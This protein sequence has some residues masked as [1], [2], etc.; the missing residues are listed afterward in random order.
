M[1]HMSLIK[2]A[3]VYAPECLG[4]KDVLL[5]G[6]KICKIGENLTVPASWD[7]EVIDGSG[8]L[9]LP[10]FIDS[11]VHVLGG[12]GEG[13]FASRTPADKP[14]QRPE[15]RKGAPVF[16][17]WRDALRAAA[18]RDIIGSNHHQGGEAP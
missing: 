8:M 13:G 7:A 14:F 2:K 12:G 17:V 10:G 15:R 1:K 9:L 6:G 4:Q 16:F 11:H 18:L 3:V 5:A